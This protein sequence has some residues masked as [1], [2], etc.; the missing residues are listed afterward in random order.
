MK[1]LSATHSYAIVVNK[2]ARQAACQTGAVP[3]QSDGP[4]PRRLLAFVYCDIHNLLLAAADRVSLQ[5]CVQM[6]R[7]PTLD[8]QLGEVLVYGRRHGLGFLSVTLA[9]SDS[10]FSENIVHIQQ[11]NVLERHQ[12]NI[13]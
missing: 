4:L 9:Q 3:P 1:R 12:L 5:N 11:S 10:F 8:C 13:K 7:S 2:V 6:K